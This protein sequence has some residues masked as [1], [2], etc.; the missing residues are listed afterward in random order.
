MNHAVLHPVEFVRGLNDNRTHVRVQTKDDV[1]V[2]I[3]SDNEQ[4]FTAQIH[5]ISTDGMSVIFDDISENVSIDLEEVLQTGK[6]TRIKYKLQISD[7]PFPYTFSFPAQTAYI[8]LLNDGKC[9]IGFQTFPNPRDIQT[10]R[11]YIFDRQTQLFK[12]ISNPS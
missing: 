2:S 11:R 5:D 12:E 8:T 4:Q 9:R 1:F 7:N 3:G 6:L 10:L